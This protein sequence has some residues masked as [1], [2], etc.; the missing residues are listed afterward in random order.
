MNLIELTKDEEGR[1]KRLA[2]D[3]Q[4]VA[5]LKKLFLDCCIGKPATDNVQVL[6]GQRLAIEDIRFAFTQLESLRLKE[7][8]ERD[9]KENVV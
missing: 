9:Y 3:K 2:S 7:E 5:A 4:T 1:L 6:A 8:A